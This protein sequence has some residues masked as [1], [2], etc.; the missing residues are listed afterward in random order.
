MPKNQLTLVTL[1]CLHQKIP[2]I[3]LWIVNTVT[4][5]S[6]MGELPSS[7]VIICT[8]LDNGSHGNTSFCNCSSKFVIFLSLVSLACDHKLA[9][10]CDCV[11]T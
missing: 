3:T 5:N 7:A 9:G 1:L 11:A 10:W 4:A 8:V 6:V 2:K